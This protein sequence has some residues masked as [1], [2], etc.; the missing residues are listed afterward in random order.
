MKRKIGFL[1]I[2]MAVLFTF[3]ACAGG[4]GGDI[5]EV[6]EKPEETFDFNARSVEIDICDPI[7]RNYLD[8]T[9]YETEFAALKVMTESSRDVQVAELSLKIPKGTAGPCSFIFSSEAD[10][11]KFSI[12]EIKI[13][14]RTHDGYT[15]VSYDIEESL[16]P[17]NEYFWK[18]T[19]KDGVIIDYGK[20]SVKDVPVRFINLDCVR[21]VRD[22]GGWTAE[23]GKR[24]SYGLVYRGTRLNGSVGGSMPL[25][26]EG[27]AKMRDELGVMTEIDLRTASDSRGINGDVQS[28]CFFGNV[29]DGKNDRNYLKCGINQYDAV[30]TDSRNYDLLQ[31]IFSCFADEKNYPIYFHCNAGADRTGTIA[32][33]LNGLLGVSFEDLT[34]DFELTSMYS[35]RWRSKSKNGAFDGTGANAS[36]LFQQD[37]GNYV[38]W[39][40]LYTDAMAFSEDG[41]L[42]N[43]IENFLKERAEITDEQIARIKSILLK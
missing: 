3:S 7:V 5:S 33:L 9:D 19:D 1:V 20:I 34:R 13:K 40:K 30:I 31:Q 24:V 14:G 41:T 37:S 21:N 39:G 17:G 16:I 15:E 23:N 27:K 8:A 28:E 2:L 35:R 10:F 26:T 12:V 4:N 11:A 25:L 29:V 22:V 43:G 38:N 32:F 36:G 18:V 42:Q 6:T